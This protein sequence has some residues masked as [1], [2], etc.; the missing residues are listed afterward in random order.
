MIVLVTGSRQWTDKSVVRVALSMYRDIFPIEVYHGGAEGADAI[1]E[2][3]CREY[4]IPTRPFLPGPYRGRGKPAPLAR[5]D[6]MLDELVPNR[7]MVVA[8]MLGNPARGGT[9]YTVNGARERGLRIVIWNWPGS[10]DY[11]E[12]LVVPR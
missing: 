6:A 9:L 7:D 8:F 1:A 3:V 2:E 12:P 4:Q 5:N 10:L 11:H